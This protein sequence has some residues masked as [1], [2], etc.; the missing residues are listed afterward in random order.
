MTNKTI[1]TLRR[2]AA[3]V[4]LLAPAMAMGQVDTS[5]WKCE[6]CPFDTGAR[7]AYDAGGIYV[8][9]DAARFGNGT[10]LD[11]K[12]GYGD[13]DGAGRLVSDD[14]LLDWT[15]EDLGVDSRRLDIEGGLQG[16]FVFELGYRELPFRRFDTTDTIFVASASDS[17]TL[18]AGWVPASTTAGFTALSSSLVPQDIGT[19]RQM[20]DVGADWNAFKRFN[21]FADFSRQT[22]DGIDITSGASFTQSS[23]LPRFID[24]ETDR[25]D[26]GVRYATD[27]ASLTLAYFGSFFTNNNPSLAWETPFTSSP[28]AA[29]LQMAREPDNDFQQVSLSGKYRFD[30]ADTILAVS[31]ATGTGEQDQTLLPYT[32]NPDIGAGALPVSTLGA[33]VDTANYALT[34]T[35]RPFD[36]ARIKFGYRYDERDN[37]TPQY[38]WNRVIVDLFAVGEAEQNTPYSFERSHLTLSGELVT[39][40]DIRISGGYDHKVIKRDFQ[41]V[42]E[43]TIDEGWGQMRWQPVA[44]FGFTAKGGASE[45]DIDRYDETVGASLGQNPL[46]R[47]Y[48]LAYRYRTYGELVASITPVE[49]PLAFTTTVLM[50]DD[51]YSQSQLGLT[52]SEEL[53]VT[54]DLSWAVSESATLYLAVGHEA[55]D[56]QQSGSEQFST[57]DWIARHDDTFDHIGAG[58]R[59][60]PVDGKFAM[61]FD[62]NR[63]DGST[64]IFVDSLSGGASN[65]PDLESTLDAARIEAS[66]AFTDRLEGTFDLRYERFELADFALV[67]ETTLPTVLT[68]GADPYDYDVYAVGVGIRWRFGDNEI[69]LAD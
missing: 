59:Y 20:I 45:R 34:L 27:R 63:G 12:G 26:A 46:M 30:V 25:I 67:S 64:S 35:S 53:R 40:K 6:A 8:S 28:G 3:P 23:L 52:D 1:N 5:D 56:A 69:K 18:P 54:A 10:G 9:D 49:S 38:D 57:F 2:F 32:I 47:K 36:K 39:W 60:A 15:F 33:E 14:Y 22:R 65:L 58:F 19:D 7:A 13:L 41:E 62:Y 37:T 42:A 44:W 43:Q 29:T 11:E 51:S 17:L 16:K 48:Y 68:L 50:T 24:Y 4:A 21:L 66:Y 61:T 31:L 55:I